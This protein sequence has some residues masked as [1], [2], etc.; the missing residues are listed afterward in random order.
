MVY[1]HVA[2]RGHIDT[3]AFRN[4]TKQSKGNVYLI[5]DTYQGAAG[6]PVMSDALCQ[7]THRT[8]HVA[9]RIVNEVNPVIY[10]PHAAQHRV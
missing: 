7:S 5:A 6:G 8:I 3:S 1:I 10:R 2:D 9:S 4:D